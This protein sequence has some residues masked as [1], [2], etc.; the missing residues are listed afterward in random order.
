[1][2]PAPPKPNYDPFGTLGSTQS[3]KSPAFPSNTASMSSQLSQQ[4]QQSNRLS[5]QDPFASLKQ[6]SRSNSPFQFQQSVKPSSPAPPSTTA[7]SSSLLDLGG[8]SQPRAQ[9]STAPAPEASVAADDEWTFTSS[10]PDAPH[11]LTVTN[12]DI[13][14]LWTVSRPPQSADA[15]QI[16]SRISN[17]AFQPITD[18]TFEVAVTKSYSLKL[19]PQSGRKLASKQK[20]GITQTIQLLGVEKGKGTSVRVRWKATYRVGGGEVKTEMGEVGSLGIA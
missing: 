18:L 19:E 20:F 7:P 16:N 3:P 6:P 15:I 1:Q 13:N 10:L 2:A 4:S 5:A 9:Q 17:N 8:I 12:S 11:E 14:V